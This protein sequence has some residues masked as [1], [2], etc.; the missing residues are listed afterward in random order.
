MTPATLSFFDYTG[1]KTLVS[2]LSWDTTGPK[3]LV[4]FLSWDTTGPKI[5]VFTTALKHWCLSYFP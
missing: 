1:H 5:L 3:T 4:S 2:F